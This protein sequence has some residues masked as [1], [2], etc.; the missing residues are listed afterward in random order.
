MR[1]KFEKSTRNIIGWS[2]GA[3][4]I[5]IFTLFCRTRL[6]FYFIF[7]CPNIL[8]TLYS[9]TGYIEMLCLSLLSSN[10]EETDE[11][12]LDLHTN[13]ILFSFACNH[14]DNINQEKRN[15]KCNFYELCFCEE[16]SIDTD[17]WNVA[18]PWYKLRIFQII[19]TGSPK[20]YTFLAIF[21]PSLR[22]SWSC[23]L[24]QWL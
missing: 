3:A 13:A 22:W 9:I 2:W 18:L 10:S 8:L 12:S 4:Q 16:K 19:C 1:Y 6:I 17:R 21:C 5:L 7:W 14:T 23:R 24:S 11:H 20:N 15:R